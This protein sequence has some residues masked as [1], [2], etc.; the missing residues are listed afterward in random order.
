[1]FTPAIKTFFKG[2]GLL[3]F[4]SGYTLLGQDITQDLQ[5]VRQES[6][7]SFEADDYR[8]AMNGFRNLMEREP[9]NPMHSYYAGRCLVELNEQL[10]EAIE[11]LYG[12]STGGVPQ[13]VIYYLGMAYLRS[14]NLN[15]HHN[16]KHDGVFAFKNF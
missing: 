2:A 4:L 12:A 16:K 14:Y 9:D 7:A 5:K 1:M 6:I 10:D 13:N 8:T 15:Q 3:L 11:L